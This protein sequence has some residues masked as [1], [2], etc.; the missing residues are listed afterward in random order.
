MHLGWTVVEWRRK[1]RRGE[2]RTCAYPGRIVWMK[3][4]SKSD[5]E[6]WADEKRTGR[7]KRTLLDKRGQMRV[8]TER[9]FISNPI[10]N[11]V[12]FLLAKVLFLTFFTIFTSLFCFC[13]IWLRASLQ[14]VL[15]SFFFSYYLACFLCYGFWL[16]DW[17]TYERLI[18]GFCLSEKM[19][20]G[21]F[22]SDHTIVQWKR[23]R[24]C[25]YIKETCRVLF[26]LILAL[27]YRLT[28]WHRHPMQRLF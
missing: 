27:I 15:Y 4:R 14:I 23:W 25:F 21:A 9:R 6:L 18:A 11:A 20:Q 24:M 19:E 7:I 13:P 5:D 26:S 12:S 3:R 16:I 22:T 28:S 8:K 1:T 10:L 17:L 2:R